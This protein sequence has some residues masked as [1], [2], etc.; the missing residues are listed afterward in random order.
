MIEAKPVVVGMASDGFTIADPV[1][2]GRQ[3]PRVW[4]DRRTPVDD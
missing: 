4:R 2:A 3:R 1:V